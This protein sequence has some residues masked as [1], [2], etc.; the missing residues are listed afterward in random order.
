MI[1]NNKCRVKRNLRRPHT[2]NTSEDELKKERLQNATF[3]KGD[4]VKIQKW[5]KNKG[6]LCIVVEVRWFDTNSVVIQYLDVEGLLDEPS[7]ANAAN[8]ILMSRDE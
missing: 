8:L 7:L 4:L 2:Y 6:R 5:C 1:S 3:R